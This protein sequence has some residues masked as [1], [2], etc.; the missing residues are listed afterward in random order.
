[1]RREIGNTSVKNSVLPANGRQQLL[2]A[3]SHYFHR[4][5]IRIVL[6]HISNVNNCN[7]FPLQT[8]AY[9]E[10]LKNSADG[11]KICG[12]AILQG[13]TRYSMSV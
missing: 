10:Q 12:Q 8:L 13:N 11:W 4:T 5:Y 1:M 9:F 3:C 7:V 2:H 6:I